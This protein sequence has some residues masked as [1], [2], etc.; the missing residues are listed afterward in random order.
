MRTED[1]G[2]SKSVRVSLLVITLLS[3]NGR[4]VLIATGV[5]AESRIDD[6]GAGVALLIGV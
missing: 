1:R 6:S 2:L 5:F 4:E 3:A